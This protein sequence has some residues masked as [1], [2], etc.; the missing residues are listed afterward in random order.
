MTKEQRML[1]RTGEQVSS[2]MGYVGEK[3]YIDVVSMSDT[4]RGNRYLLR[5]KIVLVVTVVCIMN[6]EA[7]M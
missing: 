2:L 6:K 1:V 4:V 7:H 3:L 5:G